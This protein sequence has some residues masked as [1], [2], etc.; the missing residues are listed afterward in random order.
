MRNSISTSLSGVLVVESKTCVMGYG[1]K[2]NHKTCAND[3]TLKVL[4]ML[5]TSVVVSGS[6]KLVIAKL[7]LFFGYFLL[8][9]SMRRLLLKRR[10][11][12]S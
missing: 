3:I 5:A 9:F 12:S 4:I 6:L 10:A 7:Q 8:L 1:G 2:I 11:S